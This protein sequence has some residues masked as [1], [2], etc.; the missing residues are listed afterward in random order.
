MRSPRRTLLVASALLAL[1][2]GSGAAI[3]ATHGKAATHKSHSTTQKS[4]AAPNTS[5]AGAPKSG[6]A[7]HTC[8]HMSSSGNSSSS[9]RPTGTA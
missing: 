8:P 4:N 7:Q 9:Y 2:A 1:T 6:S 3:A 5:R